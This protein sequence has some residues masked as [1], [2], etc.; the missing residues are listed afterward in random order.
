M[1]IFDQVAA[2][3]GS[4]DEFEDVPEKEGLE[5]EIPAELRQEYGLEPLTGTMTSSRLDVEEP[6]KGI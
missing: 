1:I 5:L 3:E 6:T 4:D 2:E